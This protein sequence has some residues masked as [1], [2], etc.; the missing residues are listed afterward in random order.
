MV[1]GL[2]GHQG[3]RSSLDLN[4]A[5]ELD[6]I[7]REALEKEVAALDLRAAGPSTPRA[8]RMTVVSARV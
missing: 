6:E 4:L 5:G 3:M 1:S 7:N 8:D 2:S